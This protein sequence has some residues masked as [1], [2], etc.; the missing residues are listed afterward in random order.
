MSIKQI[1]T[2]LVIFL[3]CILFSVGAFASHPICGLVNNADDSTSPL[4][5]GVVLYYPATPTT[6][7][8]CT[9][10]DD[11]G[12][13][14]YCCDLEVLNPTWNIGDVVH[15]EIYATA[16]LYFAGP[17]ATTTTGGGF[18][19]A[20]VMQLKTG[21]N[22]SVPQNGELFITDSIPINV[23]TSQPYNNTLWYYCNSTGVNTTLCTN[24][25]NATTLITNRDDGDHLITVYAN[26]SLGH[27]ITRS[28][29]AVIDADNDP[30][31]ITDYGPDNLTPEITEIEQQVFTITA[32]DPNNYS[33]ITTF[34][35]KN[36]TLI[37]AATNS[38][39]Y[40]FIG[41]LHGEDAARVYNITVEV[42]DGEFF[43]TQSW[44][45]NV[46]NYN[47]EPTTSLVK[48]NSTLNLNR[49]NETLRC[50]AQAFD[51]EDPLLSVIYEW[52][53]DG[54]LGGE[55]AYSSIT[56]NS[57]TYMSSILPGSTTKGD[58]W[59]CRVIYYDGTVNQSAWSSANMTIRDTPPVIIRTV[60]A[61]S[62]VYVDEPNGQTFNISI[63]DRDSD[64]IQVT[65]KRDAT[66]TSQKNITSAGYANQNSTFQ[67]GY[68]TSGTY[69]IMAIISDG[70]YNA[71]HS[72]T[73]HVFNTNKAPTINKTNITS[74][75]A[76][77][78]TNGTITMHYTYNDPD[79]D[80]QTLSEIIWYKNGV[81]N[82]TWTNAS[83]IAS[84]NF[85]KADI[86]IAQ[87]RGR[88][89]SNWSNWTNTS[90]FTITNAEPT[91][92]GLQ[93]PQNSYKG[94][95]FSFNFTAAD[96][97][98]IT[99]IDHCILAINNGSYVNRT[100][101]TTVTGS[102]G[103]VWTVPEN[104]NA[105]LTWNV[106]C[107][108][109][110]NT[111]ST[112]DNRIVHVTNIVPVISYLF[113]LPD[114]S[115]IIRDSNGTLSLAVQAQGEGI[116]YMNVSIWNASGI[117]Y[118]NS[119]HFSFTDVHTFAPN[120]PISTWKSMNYTITAYTENG[121]NY[122]AQQ[123]ITFMINTMP[124]VQTVTLTPTTAYANA[125]LICNVTNATDVELNS[126]TVHYTWLKNRN[127]S[128]I[129]EKEYGRSSSYDC[130]LRECAKSDNITC[131][132]TADDGTEEGAAAELTKITANYPPNVNWTDLISLDPSNR[133]NASL[134][135]YY[136]SY[137]LDGDAE[138]EARIFWYENG[139]IVTALTN[140]TYVTREYL[141]HNETWYARIQ[142]S[143]GTIWGDLAQTRNITILNTEPNITRNTP[144]IV[145]TIREPTSVNFSARITD[146]DN[147]TITINWYLDGTLAESTTVGHGNFGIHNWTFTGAYNQ[148]GNHSI[149]LYVNDTLDHNEINWTLVINNTNRAPS[150]TPYIISDDAKNRTNATLTLSYVYSD[151]DSETEHNNVSYLYKNGVLE[152]TNAT[153]INSSYIS[154][155]DTL[156]HSVKVA[157]ALEWGNF[158][159]YTFNI[160]NAAP[161]IPTYY[162]TNLILTYAELQTVT[163][164]ATTFDQD[165]DTINTTWELDDAVMLNNSL[166][167]N[168]TINYSMAGIHT[169]RFNATD[170]NISSASE[171]PSITWVVEV[172]N[173]AICGDQHCDTGETCLFC[174][175]DCG[176]CHGSAGGD[177][178]GGGG[179]GGGGLAPIFDEEE[180]S[181]AV[182]RNI[183]EPIERVHFIIVQKGKPITFKSMQNNK[184]II[185]DRIIIDPAC[186]R[187]DVTL[188]VQ[189]IERL[190]VTEPI[191]NGKPI[192]FF[193][194][195]KMNLESKCIDSVRYEFLVQRDVYK[196]L[197]MK[198]DQTVIY[199]YGEEGYW[200]FL[201]VTA[202]I[203]D[204]GEH[205]L[206]QTQSARLSYFAVYVSGDIE[207]T[208]EFPAEIKVAPATI[209]E[210]VSGI[211]KDKFLK[212]S[213]II[214]L[215][216]AALTLLAFI[217][218]QTTK[219][220]RK[221]ES[222]AEQPQTSEQKPPGEQI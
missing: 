12:N 113:P 66:V 49:T 131:R 110:G 35:Y 99:D 186:E 96:I 90:A 119:T 121:G 134:S 141:R 179:G 71:T 123:D 140:E 25:K 220:I 47:T 218:L 11:E 52:Y 211:D 106:S 1:D 48:I 31:S 86:F 217:A 23:S 184:A 170:N 40:T 39:T 94:I 182:P 129:E 37:D 17:V 59:M 108:D 41:R 50:Y 155:G 32:A 198:P 85:S 19:T 210:I 127:P 6:T 56:N 181:V 187:K 14:K 207:G 167:Y 27:Q 109:D 107:K 36:G 208:M 92:T 58:K 191:I 29:I 205:V 138:V 175:Q 212:L 104:Y 78:R 5:L 200:E 185:L 15:T 132:V 202:R 157:D 160:L 124:I 213:K 98:G 87:I 116:F 152:L 63:R 135:L 174:S 216:L 115:T 165:D 24:C 148:S 139:T 83:S 192:G 10:V 28:A 67:G 16:E 215:R 142:V 136:T 7:T 30:L 54:D 21:I 206:L 4:G 214:A 197:G 61:A 195:K 33:V 188:S 82:S 219:I 79:G 18:D 178:G 133:S 171:I 9:V 177:G 150:A 45:L 196:A 20:P 201:P 112:T 173:N 68:S 34:W 189:R 161:D 55:G 8:G 153:S 46:T 143:D 145:H 60:P 120:I 73:L 53:R 118:T 84:T 97:D 166:V 26:D 169:V 65:W 126:L 147:D 62:D 149:R 38:S 81:I 22:L 162:P 156:I 74:T 183:G 222:T 130:I 203:T 193:E 154:K 163:F 95:A 102:H 199:R 159:N 111:V 43:D 128:I 117:V 69:T 204:D 168:W 221:R 101:Y 76:K 64:V 146:H 176:N 122:S 172:T 158:S 88:D 3:L 80:A 164:N 194:V 70:E 125:T 114:N 44:T 42:T 137:D 144:E 51:M 72:W 77:N 89:G 105:T 100:N 75:D 13:N 103:L 91:I 190:P 2:M 209:T 93:P 151:P 180:E 57:L